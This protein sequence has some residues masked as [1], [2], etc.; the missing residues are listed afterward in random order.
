MTYYWKSREKDTDSR[1]RVEV[2]DTLDDLRE[3]ME[4]QMGADFEPR[5]MTIE[6]CMNDE[7]RRIRKSGDLGS[8]FYLV[9]ADLNLLCEK[10]MDA[11]GMGNSRVM[12]YDGEYS[13]H[14]NET[15]ALYYAA[16][17][18]WP[19]SEHEIVAVSS[20]VVNGTPAP[21][22]LGA[23]DRARRPSDRTPD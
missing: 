1:W 19:D 3:S 17:Q 12:E 11:H 5:I 7:E 16:C 8:E 22:I 20:D 4:S 21:I 6:E 14:R 18:R 9:I 23:S 15:E 2:H 13:G 10:A